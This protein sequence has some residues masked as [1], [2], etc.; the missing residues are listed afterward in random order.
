MAPVQLATHKSG[1]HA[2]WDRCNLM[3]LPIDRLTREQA[4]EQILTAC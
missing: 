4:I 3:G 1:Q 2:S